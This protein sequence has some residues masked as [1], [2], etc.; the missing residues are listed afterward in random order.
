LG[1]IGVFKGEYME[2][3]MPTINI[4]DANLL[5]EI[6]ETTKTI[7]IIGL[8]P[9]PSKPSHQVALYLQN[10]GFKIVPIYP[11]EEMIL[12]EKV[13]RSFSEVPEG[14]D[15]V[16]MFRKP[17]IADELVE[18]IAKRNDVKTLWLQLGIVNNEASQKARELGLHVVQNRCTKIEH[19]R[20]VQS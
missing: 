17:Q 12:G 15:M 10:V 16:D 13:Y 4:N 3:P 2:C 11:K 9:D 6:F 18:E 19:Q 7:A 5:R 8:S 20:L 1:K 14:I